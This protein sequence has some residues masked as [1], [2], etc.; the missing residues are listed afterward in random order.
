M[1]CQVF[2]FFIVDSGLLHFLNLGTWGEVRGGD[3]V[4]PVA[5]V[6]TVGGL[7]LLKG[8]WRKCETTSLVVISPNLLPDST[9]RPV[10]V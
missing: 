4:S 2:L 3:P 10:W 5:M 7:W 1:E 8:L 9:P 6:T